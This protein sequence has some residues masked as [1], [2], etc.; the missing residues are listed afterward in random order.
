M[1]R[2]QL[3]AGLLLISGLVAVTV[4]GKKPG[5][6]NG[7]FLNKIARVSAATT[8]ALASAPSSVQ[9]Q[10]QVTSKGEYYGE[11]GEAADV[12]RDN[13]DIYSV[14][15]TVAVSTKPFAS[16]PF[17]TT[18]LPPSS[19]HSGSNLG[20]SQTNELEYRE[21][22]DPD[23]GHHVTDL[24][25]VR[26]SSRHIVNEILEI[27][28]HDEHEYNLHGDEQDEHSLVHLVAGDIQKIVGGFN[29]ITAIGSAVRGYSILAPLEQDHSLDKDEDSVKTRT[30]GSAS[31]EYGATETG[32]SEEH[33]LPL[34]MYPVPWRDAYKR[35]ENVSLHYPRLKYCMQSKLQRQA[36]ATSGIFNNF[37]DLRSFLRT[38]FDSICNIFL[39]DGEHRDVDK[40]DG[41]PLSSFLDGSA[42]DSYPFWYS[43]T[44]D[45]ENG[46]M[47][48]GESIAKPCS[49]DLDF[50]EEKEVVVG[51]ER[52]AQFGYSTSTK[53]RLLGA[54]AVCQFELLEQF[55]IEFEDIVAPLQPGEA[56]SDAFGQK[57]EVKEDREKVLALITEPDDS[58]PE[59][60]LSYRPDELEATD[61]AIAGALQSFANYHGRFHSKERVREE[62]IGRGA[63]RNILEPLRFW[64]T[65]CPTVKYHLLSKQLQGKFSEARSRLD[66][67]TIRYL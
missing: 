67:L 49:A 61:G 17:A 18:S 4:T 20:L 1:A 48:G 57:V 25:D 7:N 15:G 28:D 6:K 59:G 50:S 16:A 22:H 46:R 27:P 29:F 40:A 30:K 41:E 65:L 37:E 34:T 47:N 60:A 14:H 54:Y 66:Y 9:A 36:K 45:I 3:R 43:P 52:E 58:M 24:Y 21:W 42:S 33:Y 31:Y 53:L 51:E 19:S 56:K 11:H 13:D 55:V 44:A 2:L 8:A 12:Y 63:A 23:V 5:G 38:L 35:G 26:E 64:A 62:I 32:F 39:L 10:E